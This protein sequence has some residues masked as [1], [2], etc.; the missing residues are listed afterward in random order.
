[1]INLKNKEHSVYIDFI[2]IEGIHLSHLQG[3]N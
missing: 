3:V 1:M 2:I